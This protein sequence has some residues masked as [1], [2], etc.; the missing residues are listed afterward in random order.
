MENTNTE[1]VLIYTDGCC[2]GN[3]GPGGYG[4]VLSHAGRTKELSGGFRLTTNN[5]MEI[6]AAIIAL[7]ALKGKQSVKLYSDSQYLVK[8]MEEGWAAKWQRQGWKR[9]SKEYAVNP[10][11]WERLLAIKA[12]HR[13]G[14]F[15]VKGHAGHPENERCDV[16]AKQGA[17]LP[18]LPPDPGYP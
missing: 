13:V 5:R 10:D 9:N 2:L 8:A 11:L 14:F 1:P 18:E 17:S 6:F 4:V 12:K 7:E 3:P 16:L 15:W